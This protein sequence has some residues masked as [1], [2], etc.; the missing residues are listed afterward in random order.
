MRFESSGEFVTDEVLRVLGRVFPVRYAATVSAEEYLLLRKRNRGV[1]LLS[2][3]LS[4]A[5]LAVG[6]FLPRFVKGSFREFNLWDAGVVFGLAV[7]FPLLFLF[8]VGL[9]RKPERRREFTVFYSL[10]YGVDAS[11]VLRW[12]Y[13]PLVL[14]GCFSAYMSYA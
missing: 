10:K 11:K 8:A 13:L 14:A 12:I 9:A 3:S 5:V 1:E 7:A 4:L 6:I 2:E